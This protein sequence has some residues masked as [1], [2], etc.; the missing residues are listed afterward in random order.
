MCQYPP[1]PT[2]SST[3]EKSSKHSAR[4]PV[5]EF[6]ETSNEST[7]DRNRRLLREDL[8]GKG[9]YRRLIEDPGTKEVNGQ[10]ETVNLLFLD[11]VTILKPGQLPDPQ[12]LPVS[13]AAVVVGTV[14]RAKGVRGEESRLR[15]FRLCGEDRPHSEA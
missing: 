11:G 13:S 2:L 3:L 7:A 12:G 6:G 9:F 5:G 4:P 15:I 14:L 1:L 10:A 8:H